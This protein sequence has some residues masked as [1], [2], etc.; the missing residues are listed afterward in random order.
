MASPNSSAGFPGGVSI[1]D[2]LQG[3]LDFWQTPGFWEELADTY[4]EDKLRLLVSQGAQNPQG[5]LMNL[6]QLAGESKKPPLIRFLRESLA[7]EMQSRNTGSEQDW[8][9]V[10][11]LPTET[12]MSLYTKAQTSPS[13]AADELKA[14]ISA[15][16]ESPE[17][18]IVGV[19]K[20]EVQDVANTLSRPVSPG[21]FDERP[22]KSAL[23]LAQTRKSASAAP[24]SSEA[25][26]KRMEREKELRK[27]EE[28]ELKVNDLKARTM[29]DMVK[30][31]QT[32]HGE[33]KV[34]FVTNEQCKVLSTLDKVVDKIIEAFDIPKPS[35]VIQLLLSN[36]D[37]K[38]VDQSKK[39][40]PK[41][42]R[43]L[44]VNGISPT[45]PDGYDEGMFF[46][47]DP[48][49]QH[50]FFK[51]YSWSGKTFNVTTSNGR[52][53]KITVWDER[54]DG[55]GC[56][57]R[58][59]DNAGAGDWH[60][61]DSIT[62]VTNT[63]MIPYAEFPWK[64]KRESLEAD[65]RLIMFMQNVIIPLAAETN[66]VVLCQGHEPD[67]M[68][69]MAFIKAYELKKHEWK[70]KP[71]FSVI[72]M[73]CMMKFLANGNQ[74]NK[75]WKKLQQ[76]I[77]TWKAQDVKYNKLWKEQYETD[78][79]VDLNPFLENYI[80][81]DCL[82]SKATATG[83]YNYTDKP[84]LS[85][86]N[87]LIH[88]WTSVV[89]GL[90]LV[91]GFQFSN[92][93]LLPLQGGSQVVFLDSRKRNYAELEQRLRPPSDE[94]AD[95]AKKAGEDSSVVKG[96]ILECKEE[97]DVL[98][99]AD[100]IPDGHAESSSPNDLV[101]V[102]IEAHKKARGELV[103]AGTAD[104]LVN[105]T[106][107]FFHK[108][109]KANEKKQLRDSGGVKRP[110]HTQVTEV[111]NRMAAS[112]DGKDEDVSAMI[113]YQQRKIE[114]VARYVIEANF[115]D[116]FAVLPDRE[117]R[118]KK[119][120]RMDEFLM[121]IRLEKIR[122][123]ILML[124]H[125]NM[126]SLNTGDVREAKRLIDSLVKVDRVP[127]EEPLDGLLLLSEAWDHYD[128][129]MHLASWYKRFA[130]VVYIL[131]LFL[132]LVAVTVTVIQGLATKDNNR[133][134]LCAGL[135]T[136]LPP[137][138]SDA[139]SLGLQG[140]D[141]QTASTTLF[142]I[143]V[144]SSVL[145]SIEGYQ[146]SGQR[147]RQLRTA[148]QSLESTIWRYRTRV[149][150]FSEQNGFRQPQIAFGEA[151]KTWNAELMSGSDLSS[152]SM[153]KRY[154]SDIFKHFQLSGG[155]DLKEDD[156]DYHSPMPPQGYIDFRLKPRRSFYENRIPSNVKMRL[157]L[158][159]LVFICSATSAI[160]AFMKQTPWVAVVTSF[161]GALTSWAGFSGLSS[162]VE[163]YSGTIRG[164]KDLERWWLTLSPVEQSSSLNIGELVAQGEML[165]NSEFRT[166]SS[167]IAD[168]KLA[169]DDETEGKEGGVKVDVESK[170]D[171]SK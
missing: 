26:K 25:D 65:E 23:A 78:R 95:V 10:A 48:E 148:A 170:A 97:P 134:Q 89:P 74:A 119:G 98:G 133:L 69:S 60:V 22:K 31:V 21:S 115:N 121:E 114:E 82:D 14:K 101:Q 42:P 135:T 85:F 81:N 159:V 120:E 24:A 122:E 76:N 116:M 155:K 102:A 92:R 50:N 28:A 163:R 59:V 79:A 139:N 105:E 141:R 145:I 38:W 144:C 127:D 41:K 132:G 150:E 130:K 153:E 146:N 47:F 45:S 137:E 103:A 16:V 56:Y 62:L 8:Q 63:G 57:G 151:L 147:W 136:N 118:E 71:P 35:L 44:R 156:D 117:E 123:A 154:K 66:A 108:I 143:S 107:A 32:E 51:T 162:K 75:F 167:Y 128:M 111:R 84:F 109:L 165:V 15:L 13:S 129:K 70:G 4:P 7:T 113:A 43:A 169:G 46:S 142:L 34:L 125:R 5:L 40:W 33:K 166:W 88:Y 86:T 124:S 64:N 17:L 36:G 19:M 77:K 96:T 6:Q 68:L 9:R 110:I 138:C 91:S 161:A 157:V 2:G 100:T 126:H 171:A 158:Q 94:A 131:S 99:C 106:L 30:K 53:G 164:I 73:S 39:V 149:G 37:T 80:V 168:A 90:S 104:F 87:T 20:N 49:G 3:L 12:L 52:T 160:L 58:W 140:M 1:A 152:T 29:Y 67:C 93:V 11:R 27:R 18:P 72:G 54:S 61:G 112:A 55:R 83:S